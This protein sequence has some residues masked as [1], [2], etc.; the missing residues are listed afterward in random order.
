MS[1][2][3]SPKSN[4]KSITMLVSLILIITIGVGGTL[5]YLVATTGEVKNTFTPS[6]VNISVDEKF[7]GNTKSDVKISNHNDSVKAY[8]RAAIV[9]NW[10][11]KDGNVWAENPVEG[12]DYTITYRPDMD[13]EDGEEDI[14][15]DWVEY[16]SYWYHTTPVGVGKDTDTLIASAAP[17]AGKA[18]EGYYLS[19]EI[20]AQGIQADGVD[21]NG[22]KPVELAWGVDI[23]DGVVSDATITE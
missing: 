12:E 21:A 22:N 4:K 11:D 18:P 13:D 23:A 14:D 3:L 15:N 2:Y 8:I 16:N 10:M 9:V 20:L 5:A 17:V 1:K 7:D 19:I 6:Q